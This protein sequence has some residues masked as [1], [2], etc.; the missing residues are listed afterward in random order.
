MRVSL[1]TLGGRVISVHATLG[2]RP[3]QILEV[4]LQELGG[5][6]DQKCLALFERQ[7]ESDECAAHPD[8]GAP[9]HHAEVRT[10]TSS[11]SL[12]G[13]VDAFFREP[14]NRGVGSIHLVAVHA[15]GAEFVGGH[16]GSLP[17]FTRSASA[18]FS[19]VASDGT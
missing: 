14:P 16:S 2:R 13:D 7:P 8:C 3:L 12:P 17:T 9:R 5:S 4:S 1:E 18:N 11:E 6:Q 19:S 10:F 15:Q